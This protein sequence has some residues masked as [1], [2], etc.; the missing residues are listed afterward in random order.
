[1]YQTCRVVHAIH[2]MC[3]WERRGWILRAK[4]QWRPG[5][6]GSRSRNSHFPL[7]QAFQ[8]H[9]SPLGT[10]QACGSLL[11]TT[12]RFFCYQV[13]TGVSIAD[14]ANLD[15]CILRLFLGSIQKYSGVS[16]VGNHNGNLLAHRNSPLD[17]GP[18]EMKFF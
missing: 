13:L 6:S 3:R 15:L 16:T 2:G 18:C 9:A 5:A 4:I 1:M 11:G 14:E 10:M 7:R 8:T 17:L 12:N